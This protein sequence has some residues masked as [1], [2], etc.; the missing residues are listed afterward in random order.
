MVPLA[1]YTGWNF[2]HPQQ[3]D[4]DMLFPLLGSYVPFAATAVARGAT[5]DPRR[6]VA[7]RYRDKVDFLNQVDE[8]ARDLVTGRYLLP[9]DLNAVVQRASQHWDLVRGSAP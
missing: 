3:G 4:P 6:S 5:N 1:T 2:T 8:A 9:G 7:E